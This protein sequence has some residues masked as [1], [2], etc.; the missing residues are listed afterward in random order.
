GT[1]V[2]AFYSSDLQRARA[3]AEG[4]GAVLG[5]APELLQELREVGLGEWEGKTR[6]EI[7]ADYP[8]EWRQWTEE[9]S[10]DVVPGGE[11]TDPFGARGGA[12]IDRILHGN[13]NGRVPTVTHVAAIQAALLRRVGRSCN[14]LCPF[15]IDNA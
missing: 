15:T 12:A 4:I 8:E 9:P 10:R 13:A 6:E 3:T 14:G 2:D 7:I 1:Q 11:G 5:R